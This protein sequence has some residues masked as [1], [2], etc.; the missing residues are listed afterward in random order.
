MKA[1]IISLAAVTSLMLLSPLAMAEGSHCDSL[2]GHGSH[3]MS[4]EAWQQF[5]HNHTWMFS[6]DAKDV[7]KDAAPNT[8]SNT[9]KEQPV[10]PSP[11]SM[12]I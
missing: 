10:K 5:K 9:V 3:D 6:E 12:A 2:K 1:K 7:N 11:D 8:D 4:S